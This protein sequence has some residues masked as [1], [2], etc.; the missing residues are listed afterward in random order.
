[1]CRLCANLAYE[2][3][4]SDAFMR[5]ITKTNKRLARLGW[6]RGKP[7]PPK[8]KGMHWRTFERLV[9]ECAGAARTENAAFDAWMEYMEREIEHIA[10]GAAVG[11]GS[12]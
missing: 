3:A 9:A 11:L 5:A 4:Q 10:Q 8:P 2:T 7:F 1:M 6:E 12:S